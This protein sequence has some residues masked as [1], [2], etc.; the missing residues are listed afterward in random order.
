MGASKAMFNNI[1]QQEIDKAGEAA[2]KR[3]MFRNMLLNK[4]KQLTDTIDK[5][6]LST[7]EKLEPF[8]IWD[9]YLLA[10]MESPLWNM[11]RVLKKYTQD[12]QYNIAHS[13][14]IYLESKIMELK[15]INL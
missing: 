4:T 2:I 15:R 5:K 10:V 8:T 12:D 14:L 11:E 9:T 7:I 3:A 6:L 13:Y 1:R